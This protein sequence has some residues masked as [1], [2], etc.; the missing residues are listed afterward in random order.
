MKQSASAPAPASNPILTAPLLPLLLRM[1][2]PNFLA[3]GASFLVGIAETAYAGTL[4]TLPLAGLAL[5]FPMVMMLQMMSAGAMG[6]GVSSAIAR[7]LGAGDEARAQKL[8][9][10]ALFI[11]LCAGIAYTVVFLL[12][13]RAIYSFLGGRAQALEEAMAFSNIIFSGAIAVWLCNTLVSIIRGAGN[14]NVPGSTMIAVAAIQAIL[15]AVFGLG[16]GPVPSFGMAGIAAAQVI[17]YAAGTAFLLWYLASGRTRITPRLH[18]FGLER[19]MFFDILKVGAIAC[20][21]PLQNVAT[22]MAFTAFVSSAGAAALAGYGVGA[23][24][25]LLLIPATFAIGGACVP[26]VGMAIGAGMV[27]RAR[28]VAW[29]GG[30]LAGALTGTIGLIVAIFPDLWAGLFTRDVEVLEAA[31]AYL[32]MAGPVFFIFGFGHCTYFAA[33]GSGKILGPVLAGTLRLAIVLA[34]GWMLMSSTSPTWQYYVLAA[35]AMAVYGIAVAL[36]VKATK[37]GK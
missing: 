26:M 33:Q 11:S 24:L 5:V 12:F 13:G 6:G 22:V 17:A 34:G 14:M 10:H 35:F 29:T 23:R 32:R 16:A 4:G 31:R 1:S 27:E 21:S 19:A 9:L 15:G 36:F 30:L 2:V 37:W 28:R 8:V 18:G 3:M 20:I 7:A 25:E